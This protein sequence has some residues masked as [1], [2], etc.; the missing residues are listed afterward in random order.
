MFARRDPG[1]DLALENFACGSSRAN[2]V[3]ARPSNGEF[4]WNSAS[5]A[6]CGVYCRLWIGVGFCH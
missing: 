5:F 2:R 6:I 4:G 1:S 3:Q